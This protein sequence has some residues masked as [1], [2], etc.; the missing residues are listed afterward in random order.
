[1]KTQGT[2]SDDAGLSFF[3]SLPVKLRMNTLTQQQLANA[4]SKGWDK[5]I[6]SMLDIDE[7]LFL[8]L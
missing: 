1:M 5:K 3:L 7:S 4:E 8:P 2:F 6:L